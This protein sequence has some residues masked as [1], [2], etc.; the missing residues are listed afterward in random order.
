MWETGTG[1]PVG[2]PLPSLENNYSAVF[3]PDGNRIIFSNAG[4]EVFL[5][6][7]ASGERV[8]PPIWNGSSRRQRWHIVPTG[9]RS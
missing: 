6:D 2:R 8:G 4:N 3:S 5:W 7:V 1:T 9:T